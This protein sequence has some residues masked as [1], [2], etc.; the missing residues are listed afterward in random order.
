MKRDKKGKD[1]D[2]EMGEREGRKWYIIIM[3]SG[4]V[5]GK[6]RQGKEWMRESIE[7][8]G[9]QLQTKDGKVLRQAGPKRKP[10]LSHLAFVLHISGKVCSAS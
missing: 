1:R 9:G 2:G 7:D 3:K 4:E 8:E 5:Q 10:C 6:E